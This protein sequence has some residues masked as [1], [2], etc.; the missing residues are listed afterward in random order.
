MLSKSDKILIFDKSKEYSVDRVFLFGSCTHQA[1]IANDIDLGVIGLA[2]NKFFD[3]YSDLL[4][5]LSKPL[6]LIDLTKDTLF[7]SIIKENGI[8]LYDKSKKKY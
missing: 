5:S 8:L 3:F 6:D 4:F 1:Q 2:S 7:N